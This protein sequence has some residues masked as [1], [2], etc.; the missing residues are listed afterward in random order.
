MTGPAPPYDLRRAERDLAAADAGLARMIHRVGRCELRLQHHVNLFDALLHAV[1]H[2]QLS[3]QAAGRIHARVLACCGEGERAAALLA[4]DD[5]TLLGAGLSRPKLRSLRGIAAR[6]AAGGLP[7]RR[8]LATMDDASL[9]ATLT[10][11]PG[12]GA[13]TVH[14]LQMQWL[15]RPD[16]LP[17]TDLGVRKGLA[18]LRGYHEP[19]SA[20]SVQ[21][22]GER[23]RPWRSVASWYLWRAAE[24]TRTGARGAGGPAGGGR[25]AREPV[26]TDVSRSE[27]NGSRRPPGKRPVRPHRA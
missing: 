19:P 4:L 6:A 15:G 14:M 21:A 5:A 25:M 13:W 26:T 12:V 27:G 2:Q 17:A 10:A 11:L 7:S 9:A 24:D 1:V 18:R 23:W 8:R 3:G 20:G 16:V 22:E